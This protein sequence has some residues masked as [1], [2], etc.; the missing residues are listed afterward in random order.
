MPIPNVD[1]PPS[2]IINP[3]P[4]PEFNIDGKVILPNPTKIK[5]DEEGVDDEHINEGGE[6]EDVIE[7]DNKESEDDFEV[8][9]P[10]K[11]PTVH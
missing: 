7:D 2:N 1:R 10:N 5:Q 11:K 9:I 6:E 8:N 3:Y 4:L